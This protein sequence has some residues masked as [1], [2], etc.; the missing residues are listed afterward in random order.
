[1]N[2]ELDT[3]NECLAALHM[4][5]QLANEYDVRL[6]HIVDEDVVTS[7]AELDSRDY[8]CE[9]DHAVQVIPF[10]CSIKVRQN[11]RMH[12]AAKEVYLVQLQSTFSF[13]DN[14]QDYFVQSGRSE[15]FGDELQQ[16]AASYTSSAV[17]LGGLDH[18][19]KLSK[20]VELKDF[21]LEGYHESFIR[22]LAQARFDEFAAL[23][24]WLVYIRTRL[25]EFRGQPQFAHLVKQVQFIL[26]RIDQIYM[27]DFAKHNVLLAMAGDFAP[28][29]NHL[30]KTEREAAVS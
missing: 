30:Q 4:I 12:K 26:A 13:T 14:V 1:M 2:E 18:A 6:W 21:R 27:Y 25:Q 8:A 19:L 10:S 5:C 22:D 9:L 3:Y 15:I 20:S 23:L 11:S 29:V 17:V 16:F 28:L 24:P 7:P